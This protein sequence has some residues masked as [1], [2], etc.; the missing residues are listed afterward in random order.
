[1]KIT[2]TCTVFA[3]TEIVSLLAYGAKKEDVLAGLHKSIA[4]RVGA[5]AK[6]VG[7]R[8][9]VLMTGGVSKNI[10]V[11][12]ALED[13]LGIEVVIPEKMDP[14]LVGALGASLIAKNRALRSS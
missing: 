2:S 7:V 13:E 4:K 3:Q 6:H 12:R 11:R 1:V 14:Q 10:G 8:P 9:V 5:L